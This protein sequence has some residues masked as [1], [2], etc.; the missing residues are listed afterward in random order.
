M[1]K[2][3]FVENPVDLEVFSQ[4]DESGI[5]EFECA[6]NER[7][8]SADVLKNYLKE[9]QNYPVLSKEEE[10]KLFKKIVNGDI[11]ARNR[12]IEGNLKL[13]IFIAKKF[14]NLGIPMADIIQDGNEGLI[15]AT[16]KFDPQ[17]GIKFSTYAVYWIRQTIQRGI[18]KTQRTVRL[19]IHAQEVNR[20]INKVRDNHFQQFG[21]EPSRKEISS[22]LGI[23]EEKIEH[24]ALATKYVCSLD[25]PLNDDDDL[26]LEV[27]TPDNSI[28]NLD[29][30]L[31]RQS[32]F[33]ELKN[34]LNFL[35]EREKQIICA[36]FGLDNLGNE[37][38]LDELAE[39]FLLSKERI[40]QIEKKAIRKMKHP[41]YSWRLRQFQDTSKH[42]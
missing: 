20:S 27:I 7:G 30:Y 25:T 3:N 11:S 5:F 32:L 4:K 6:E 40:R 18:Y 39:M 34:V 22:I 42:E 36:R 23:S 33:A 12:V 15:L 19:P 24:L 26:T 35:S 29:D 10:V 1:S 2:E 8:Q 28:E 21:T 14:S 31:E 41:L 13:V 38:S 17:K 16:Q 37:K 9:L